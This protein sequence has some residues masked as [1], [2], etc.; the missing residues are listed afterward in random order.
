MGHDYTEGEMMEQS[1]PP[2]E[3]E[4]I[5]DRARELLDNSSA[6]VRSELV[7]A[8]GWL[9]SANTPSRAPGW[10]VDIVAGALGALA[11]AWGRLTLWSKGNGTYERVSQELNESMEQLVEV[12]KR[13]VREGKTEGDIG[14]LQTILERFQRVHETVEGAN[15]M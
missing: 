10:Q 14:E 6:S 4:I 8:D 15:P 12:R 1:D 3:A 2:S 13:L 5:E 9:S 7:H 11:N